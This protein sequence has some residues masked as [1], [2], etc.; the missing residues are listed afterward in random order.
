MYN[1]TQNPKTTLKIS[2]Y[3]RKAVSPVVA[4]L[5][6]IVIAIVGAVGVGLIL[7]NVSTNVGKQANP[8]N[9]G[10]GAQQTLLIGGSTTV[11]PITEA[12][13]ASF[14]SQ[15]HVNVIDAQG[16][17]DAGMQGVLSGALDI[18]AASSAGAVNNLQNAIIANNL[19]SSVTVNAVLIGGSVVVPI[20]NGAGANGLLQDATP[21]ECLG[22][23]QNALSA[24]FQLGSFGIL[25]GACANAAPTWQILQS[26][27]PT[28][29]A[30]PSTTICTSTANALNTYTL[31]DGTAFT[32]PACAAQPPPYTA[33]S[34]SDN[35]GTQDQ[36]A[37]FLAGHPAK[38][39]SGGNWAGVTQQGNAGVLNYVNSHSGT[40]GFADL[41]FAEG[42]ATGSICPSPHP[43]QTTCGVGMPQAFTTNKA[44]AVTA[45][46]APAVMTSSAQGYVAKGGSTTAAEALS[47]AALKSAGSVNPLTLAGQVS[48]YPDA[49]APG[50]GLART[51][52]YVTNGT[53]TPLESQWLSFI[54]NFNQ[55]YAY[56]NNG[57]YSQ[58]DF[59]Q[60]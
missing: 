38:Q 1:L 54:T 41:G 47:K 51:F 40:I 22:V 15:Y 48:V 3:N 25:A 7:S 9:A 16:G 6:L 34:R 37:S 50:T 31:S 60:A 53:P 20:E 32:F 2:K 39:S 55:E 19:Q 49:K 57:Y 33:V 28:E 11:F 27:T 44:A 23:S 45:S 30:S 18:G 14:Q 12:A 56:T 42:A 4:T 35:S 26:S 46:A 5:V 21:L 8:G 17:S 52:Y 24:I 59:T 13:K 58:Y 29:N 10:Q 43:T 36:M